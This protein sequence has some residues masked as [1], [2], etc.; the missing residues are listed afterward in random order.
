MY[1]SK[2]LVVFE[3][4]CRSLKRGWE[5]GIVYEYALLQAIVDSATR[6][7]E[8]ISDVHPNLN[9]VYWQI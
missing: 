8:V 5:K 6:R 3:E 4:A 9:A 1:G 2:R 7:E